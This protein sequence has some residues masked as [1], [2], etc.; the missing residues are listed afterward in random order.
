MSKFLHQYF[1]NCADK[2]LHYFAIDERHLERLRNIASVVMRSALPVIPS[3]R[4]TDCI[5]CH[6]RVVEFERRLQTQRFAPI[7]RAM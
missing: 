5:A 1:L 6:D 3:T 2:G 4:S 7:T